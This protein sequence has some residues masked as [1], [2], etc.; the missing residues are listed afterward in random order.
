MGISYPSAEKALY[1]SVPQAKFDAL[2]ARLKTDKDA[3]NLQLFD[4]ETGS[5]TYQ[6][7]DFAWSY[8]AVA[9]E[10]TVVIVGD[11]NWKAKIAG[12]QEIFEMLNEKLIS[13][14]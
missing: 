4:N 3:R 12:N 13:L 9:A 5:V 10:L 2:I 14:A 6:K 8:D 11:H 7:I 1:G